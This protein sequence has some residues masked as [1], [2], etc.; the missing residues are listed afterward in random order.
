MAYDYDTY[1]LAKKVRARAAEVIQNES[2]VIQNDE[3]KVDDATD[4]I[5]LCNKIISKQETKRVS[6]GYEGMG[7]CER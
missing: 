4:I 1:E 5:N 3:R 2:R 6:G 7:I